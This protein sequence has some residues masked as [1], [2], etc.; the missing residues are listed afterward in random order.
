MTDERPKPGPGAR[1]RPASEIAA[2]RQP[3]GARARARAW[4]EQML[5]TA[6]DGTHRG[7][8]WGRGTAALAPALL[9]VV[10]LSVAITEG[11]LAASFNVANQKF[12]LN[13][14]SLEGQGLGAVMAAENVRNRDSSTDRTGVLHAGLSSAKLSDLCIVVHES[15]LGVQYTITVGAGGSAKSD[16]QNLYFDITDLNATPATLRNA[17]LGESADD[18]AV[19]GNSLGGTPGGFG[20]DVTRG[21]VTLQNV[22]GSAYQAQVAGSL[23][24]PN[25][26]INVK[27]GESNSC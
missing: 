1:P 8:R 5:A 14:G 4:N 2:G 10:G 7:V 16:G 24:L 12:T 21:S 25:L 22:H 9:A 13:V 17:V 11:V 6:Q 3:G 23:T 19:N 27:L 26:A 18:V 15:V 20:L